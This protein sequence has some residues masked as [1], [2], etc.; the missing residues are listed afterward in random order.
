MS[1]KKWISANDKLLHNIVGCLITFFS[2]FILY[3]YLHQSNVGSWII[4]FALGVFSG[5]IKEIYDKKIKK[6]QF[7][8]LDFLATIWGSL[9][10]GVM[11]IPYFVTH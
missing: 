5:F 11:L 2:A 7:S 4:G 9:V 8:W 1:F 3:R 6:T 10:G